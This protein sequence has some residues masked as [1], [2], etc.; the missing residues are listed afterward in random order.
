MA[1][2]EFEPDAVA[3]VGASS[4]P[5][6]LSH[7][8]VRY[9]QEHGYPGSIYPVNPNADSV[10]GV[11]AH[12][13]IASLP[14]VP[15]LAMVMLP[16]SLVVEAVAEC[17]EAGVDTL[18]VVSSGFAETGGDEAIAA[19]QRLAALADGHD[20]ALVGPNSQGVIDV[21]SGTTASFTP[22][23]ERP[24][25]A[26]GSV[27]FVTQSG[28]FGGALTTMLQNRGVGLRRWVSTGN[29]AA[30]GALD[31]VDDLANDDGTAVV[32]GYVEGFED[33]R[34]LVELRRS[35]A[36]VDLPVVLLKVG[37]SE[38]G[39]VAAESHTGTLAGDHAVYESVFRELGVVAVDEVDGFVDAVDALDR[40]DVLPGERVGVVTTSGGAGVH[41]A[42]I[43]AEEG[44]VLPD[45]DGETGE[46][47]ESW[48]PAY[49][50]AANP[51]DIT[52]QVAGDPEA[53]GACLDALLADPDLETAVLQVTN[54][55][56]DRA[57]AFAE[58]IV[59]VATDHDT[60]LF[61]C[62]TGGVDLS[63]ATDTLAD[64]G[65][66]LFENPARC[67]RT[68]A[69]IARFGT[70][71]PAL[72]DAMD[73]PARLPEPGDSGTDDA[74]TESTLP[75]PAA[76][77]LLADHGVSVPAGDVVESPDEAVRIAERIGY[78]VVAKLV[79]PDIAHRSRVD[80]VRTGLADGEA[81]RGATA[82]LFERGAGLD[83]TLDGISVQEQVADGVEL[84]T[85]IVDSDFGPVVMLGRGGTDIETIDDVAF[86]TIP[87]TEP[88]ARSMVEEL[89]T[90]PELSP[91]SVDAVVEVV[92]SL[93][94]CS[95]ENPWI[96]E[97]DVNPVVVRDGRATA[98][99]ALVV[100]GERAGAEKSGDGSA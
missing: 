47:V 52:A 49:G 34:K 23:L 33:G 87:V 16:A 90:V 48:I 93:S 85:G 73:L 35:A 10:A 15:D 84:A 39:R 26:A 27:S 12:P 6:K 40:L 37:E 50:S 53:F 25:I 36:G 51:V 55:S 88:A 91:A 96:V 58:R 86:R 78:P 8:P 18:V 1:T 2:I 20:A 38:R 81:V 17:L 72:E 61:V 24:D 97:V 9:L 28:A 74:P 30:L 82:E 65:I 43:A 7:R 5:G 77:R 59:A 44:L 67:V 64:A 3:V 13:D 4:D 41:I 99:D 92:R 89:Q 60:P 62:W 95:V 80:G 14:E 70:A 45:L 98:V 63:R 11:P 83:A 94:A 100:A 56:G 42:D 66:P 57:A 68:V 21:D 29:E 19:Q 76:K 22:A 69:A 32:A 31:V 79:S 75:E 54:I 46:T 71:V